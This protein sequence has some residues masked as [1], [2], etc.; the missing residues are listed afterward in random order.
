MRQKA[1]KTAWR[2]RAA[3]PANRAATAAPLEKIS[4]HRRLG[5]LSTR[6]RTNDHPLPA[7]TNGSG[8]PFSD[9]RRGTGR[10][11]TLP[12]WALISLLRSLAVEEIDCTVRKFAHER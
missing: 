10:G 1:A 11:I 3:A 5:K 2:G 4:Y 6:P 9:W 7:A 8:R 12:C